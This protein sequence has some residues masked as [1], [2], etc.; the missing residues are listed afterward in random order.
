[1]LHP[2]NILTSCKP[3]AR[4]RLK[5]GEQAVFTAKLRKGRTSKLLDTPRR[6]KDE[7]RSSITEGILNAPPP[8][9]P[10]PCVEKSEEY[11]EKLK[12][13]RA[14]LRQK[15]KL[16]RKHLVDK[17]QNKWQTYQRSP[18]RDPTAASL[19]SLR[20]NEKRSLHENLAKAES[21]QIRT[22]VSGK[23]LHMEYYL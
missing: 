3:R 5:I 21:F 11:T 17:W 8:A 16:I 9:C 23:T 22:E 6:R 10:P 7:W 18:E 4:T 14:L 13:N 19:V 15:E 2:K 1:M 12:I 20:R